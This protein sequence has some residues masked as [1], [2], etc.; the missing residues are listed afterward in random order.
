MIGLMVFA[1]GNPQEVAGLSGSFQV[2]RGSF[3]GISRGLSQVVRSLTEVS[4]AQSVASGRS[5]K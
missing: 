3:A 1:A 2:F 4:A 5:S